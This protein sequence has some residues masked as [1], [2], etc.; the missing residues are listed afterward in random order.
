MPPFAHL[1]GIPVEEWLPFVAPVVVLYLLGR[2]TMRRR[3]RE[4]RRIPSASELLDERAVERVLGR[5]GQTRHR[6]LA[7]RHVPIFYPPGPDGL[8]RAELS[9]HADSSP[10]QLAPLLD[11]LGDLGYLEH[12]DAGGKVWLTV[13]GYDALGEAESVLLEAAREREAAQAAS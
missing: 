4:V 9:Q 2:R 8:T 7:A 12:E 10:E 3:E 13:E 11:E 5:W 6:D 1:A